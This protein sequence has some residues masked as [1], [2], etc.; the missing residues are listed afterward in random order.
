MLFKK[1]LVAAAVSATPALAHYKDYPVNTYWGQNG[2]QSFSS[3]HG[4]F[5]SHQAPEHSPLLCLS[6]LVGCCEPWAS[7]TLT[8]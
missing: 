5:M 1:S 7:E 2:K 8:V 3:Y 4:V 6:L